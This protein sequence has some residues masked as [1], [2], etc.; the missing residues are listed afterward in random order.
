MQFGHAVEVALAGPFLNLDFDLLDVFAHLVRA[1][2]GGFFA[3]PDFFQVVGFA[4]QLGELLFEQR[5]A[6]LRGLVFF[7]AHRLALDLELDHA[8]IQLVHRL[9]L[10]VD[11]DL[12]FGRGFVD[13]VDGLVGQKAIR[14][15]A[16]A[17]L[18]RGDDGR[19]GDFHAV[20]HFVLF[21]QAAQDGDGGLH[22]G[23]IDQHLL[24]AP[25]QRRVFFHVFAVFVER[26]GTDAVQLAARQRRFEHVAG[27]DRALGPARPDHGVQL[28]DEQDDAALVG[29]H[30][31]EHRFQPLLELAPV[32]GPGQQPG[33]VEHQHALVFQALGHFARH[34]ALRQPFDDG[35][36]AHARLADQHRVVFA[37][38]LQHLDGA[39]DFVV[40]PNHRVQL[41][42][43]GA[44]G[45][46][47]GVFFQCLALA[48]G[49]GAVHFLAA[50]QRGN[51]C[52]QRLALEASLACGIG[53]R[54]L[55]VGQ[56]QQ[57]QLAGH[58][59]V[60]ALEGFFFCR[61]QQ[62]HAIAPD[63][64]L[65]LP[66]HR[67]QLGQ[68]LVG[69]LRQRRHIDPGAL[70]QRLGAVG[71]AQQGGEQVRRFDVGVILPQR[72]GLSFVEGLLEFG[73]E[74]VES[75]TPLSQRVDAA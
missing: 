1:L 60:A 24:E 28:V 72:Q 59:L 66:L 56:R 25:L 53:Q 17:E 33:H 9:G 62:P 26:G 37:A 15:V 8:P 74:F 11:L 65:L 64:H 18:G 21:L 70:Q 4:L 40:A 7:F 51:R 19:V 61:L 63:L 69:R 36:F 48:F 58:E 5:H 35:G 68:R 34:D 2:G 75:H 16:V 27:V 6:L 41:A 71:L 31:F 44:L 3:F 20:V 43:A 42:G 14:D 47:E 22:A 38:P 29:G 73:G 10:G 57:K 54:Q 46:V 32:F 55:A 12:D 67:G 39:P 50:A 23:L 45:Q 13:Q 52:L 30:F 49:L